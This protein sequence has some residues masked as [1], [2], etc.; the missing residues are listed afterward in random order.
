MQRLHGPDS[1]TRI[2][3]LAI[4][5][6][7]NSA[8]NE[9][10]LR[11][12]GLEVINLPTL[13]VSNSTPAFNAKQPELDLI[14]WKGVSGAKASPYIDAY[15]GFKC[16]TKNWCNLANTIWTTVAMSGVGNDH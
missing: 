8:N 3:R 1:G 16:C 6:S 13:S 10:H 7:P 12:H 4:G 14:D 9:A 2:Q 11:D 15:S 5:N